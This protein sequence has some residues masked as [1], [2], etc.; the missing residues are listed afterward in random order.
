M[1]LAAYTD[2]RRRMLIYQTVDCVL[3]AIAQV[4][5]G[6]PSG[7][8][9]LMLGATR[10]LIMLKGRFG[11]G[12]MIC[13]STLSVVLGTLTNSSGLLGFI[14]I[15]AS[16]VL[17][18]G[19]YAAE[20]TVANKLVIFLNL[21]IWSAYSFVISDFATGVSNGASALICLITLIAAIKENKRNAGDGR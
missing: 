9:V 8:S 5:F 20:S 18:V 4:I 1:S 13:F 21:F 15:I 19:L 3:L 2:S 12:M 14:P 7:A 17:T 6:I 16:L 10:N 11:F